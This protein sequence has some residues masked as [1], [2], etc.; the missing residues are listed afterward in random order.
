[1][2][3]FSTEQLL[4]FTIGVTLIVI[5]ASALT[6]ETDAFEAVWPFYVL[7]PIAAFFVALGASE[8]MRRTDSDG[9]EI[10][11]LDGLYDDATGVI[12][13]TVA[14]YEDLV[15]RAVN[16]R[17]AEDALPDDEIM[18][19]VA[20]PDSDSEPVWPGY[21]AGDEWLYPNGLVCRPTHWARMPYPPDTF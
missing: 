18:V 1:M 14:E 2:K 21:H 17:S 3:R 15:A 19:L 20:C 6:L 13:L 7:A 10:T 9:R 4:C 16:W 8:H 12:E 5:G 11:D